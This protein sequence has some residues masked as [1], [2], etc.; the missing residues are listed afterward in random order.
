MP[1]ASAPGSSSA[2]LSASARRVTCGLSTPSVPPDMMVSTRSD[3][4]CSHARA[5]SSRVKSLTRPFPSVLPTTAR[6]RFKSTPLDR[7]RSRPLVSLGPAIGTRITSAR[8]RV[9]VC[10]P[11]S[12]RARGRPSRS[13]SFAGGAL[14]RI[15]PLDQTYRHRFRLA[16]VAPAWISVERSPASCPPVLQVCWASSGELGARASGALA[17]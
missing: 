12:G 16:R 17:S 8:A 3:S 13:R 10:H 11:P 4:S 9:Q 1:R 15:H 2:A 14:A 5:A 6:M 7:R